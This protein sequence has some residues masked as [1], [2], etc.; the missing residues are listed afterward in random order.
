MD[1]L[2]G[3]VFGAIGSGYLVYAKRQYSAAFALAGAALILYSYFLTNLAAILIT[4]AM[5]AAAPFAWQR[6]SGGS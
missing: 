4:G 6:W 3:L 2:L 5:L 1:L